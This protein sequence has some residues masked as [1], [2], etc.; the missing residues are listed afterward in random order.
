MDAERARRI[1]GNPDLYPEYPPLTDDER[2]ALRTHGWMVRP[3]G[4]DA[5]LATKPGDSTR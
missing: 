3:D 4:A 1:G 5:W 2:D